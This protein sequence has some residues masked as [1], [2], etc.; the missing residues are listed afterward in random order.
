[1]VVVVLFVTSFFV[2][3]AVNR[4]GTR[5]VGFFVFG[6]TVSRVVTGAFF[7]VEYSFGRLLVVIILS[8]VEVIMLVVDTV[9]VPSVDVDGPIVV[10]WLVDADVGELE[11]TVICVEA[12]S[13][14]VVRGICVVVVSLGGGVFGGGGI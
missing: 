12:I 14:G 6:F 5:V 4:F 3:V 2:V 7:V 13:L 11:G 1:M 10:S 9:D 8:V